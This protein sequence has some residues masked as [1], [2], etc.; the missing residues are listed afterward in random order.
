MMIGVDNKR[1]L[2]DGKYFYQGLIERLV[3]TGAVKRINLRRGKS[4]SESL[5]PVVDYIGGSVR[6]CG[7]YC[8]VKNRMVQYWDNDLV[9]WCKAG[10]EPSLE[11]E[12]I[13]LFN[14]MING[15]AW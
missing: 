14:K 15:R 4:R 3:K 5:P 13:A 10:F 8:R 1:V 7:R 9:C 11:R 2:C 6:F 12:C